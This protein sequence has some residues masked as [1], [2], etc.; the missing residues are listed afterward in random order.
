LYRAMEGGL[1]VKK[2]DTVETKRLTDTT[3]GLVVALAEASTEIL[4]YSD[5]LKDLQ[6]QVETSFQGFFELRGILEQTLDVQERGTEGFKSLSFVTSALRDDVLEL[7]EELRSLNEVAVG[8]S[9]T[10]K[11]LEEV[12]EGLKDGTLSWWEALERLNPV[13]EETKNRAKASAVAN[14]DLAESVLY[15]SEK[16]AELVER[17][18]E[19]IQVYGLKYRALLQ[20]AQGIRTWVTEAT[21]SITEMGV[22]MRRAAE[23]PLA[24]LNQLRNQVSQLAELFKQAGISVQL[25]GEVLVDVQRLSEAFAEALRKPGAIAPEMAEQIVKAFEA[26]KDPMLVFT[27]YFEQITSKWYDLWESVGRD[28]Q[29][30]FEN[31]F[32]RILRGE[33]KGFADF[34]NAIINSLI[35]AW[36]RFISEL[37]YIQ[38]IRPLLMQIGMWL[39]G[40]LGFGFA[41]G[42]LVLSPR[43][44]MVG[45]EG[46]EL[47]IPLDRFKE[48]FKFLPGF[49]VGAVVTRPTIAQV[50]ERGPEAIIPLE[51][52]QELRQPIYIV[53]VIGRPEDLV[54]LGISR[55]PNVVI[56]PLL[57]DARLR[58]PTSRLVRWS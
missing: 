7:A 23:F 6:S 2:R 3:L 18:R 12:V 25:T 32:G 46:P 20:S 52:M 9:T 13:V 44:A 38:V 10:S 17:I 41:K 39:G 22:R 15:G 43:L 42:G 57:Q 21:R 36:A 50:A 54:Q 49:Q 26:I 4:G 45:E 34:F 31:L 8:T 14:K 51:R 27:R 19:M 24:A 16:V 48:L 40:A 55:L 35:N 5:S 33:F 1:A 58:G 47:I 37:L 53:N 29:R 30:S 28:I 56:N 11:E